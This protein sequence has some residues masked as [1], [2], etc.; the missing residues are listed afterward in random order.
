MVTLAAYVSA[1]SPA[2][3]YVVECEAQAEAIVAEALRPATP[4]GPERPVPPTL[5]ARAVLEVG[6]ELYARRGLRNGVATFGSADGD[7]QPVRVSR[8]PMHLARS[9]LA[10]YIGGPFA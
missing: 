8:D 7:L 3:P 2:D 4:G 1:T 5:R 6:A 9:I 10:P